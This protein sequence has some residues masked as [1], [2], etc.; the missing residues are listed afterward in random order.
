MHCT[1][2]T[3]F[4]FHSQFA[5]LVQNG[6]SLQELERYKN[7]IETKN[8]GGGRSNEVLKFL[9]KL[10]IIKLE[11]SLFQVEFRKQEKKRKYL[12]SFCACY[13]IG[14][15]IFKRN[16]LQRITRTVSEWK[17]FKAITVNFRVL[18]SSSFENA[19]GSY[20]PPP[21]SPLPVNINIR[22]IDGCEDGIMCM[23]YCQCSTLLDSLKREATEKDDFEFHEVKSVWKVSPAY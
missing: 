22:N 12:P 8:C 7:S 23:K 19:L 3:H 20:F 4:Q 9:S 14:Y 16:E 21:F 11:K 17:T 18:S 2:L 13:L 10:V 1:Q 5:G 6:L 15:K